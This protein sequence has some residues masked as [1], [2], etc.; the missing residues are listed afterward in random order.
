MNVRTL[1]AAVVLTAAFP[2][3][4]ADAPVPAGAPGHW[5]I[6]TGETV[7]PDRDAIAFEMGWPGLTFGYLHGFS[8]RSDIGMMISL[9]YAAENTNNS[10]FGAGFDLPLRLIVQRHEKVSIG[11]DIVPGLRLYTKNSVTNFLTRFPVGGTLG[12]QATPELRLAA[13]ADLTMAI[14]WTH[15]TYFEIGPQFG[16]AAEYAV[17]RN[18]MVGLQAKFGPQFYTVSGSDTD[19][20]F[21]TLVTVGYRM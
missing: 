17:D 10:T 6:A 11:L 15:T 8:D 20:A 21:T 9:L 7:T 1:C 19:F 5:S 13:S 2:I 12:I 16:F 3:F 4:A 18:L 14:N